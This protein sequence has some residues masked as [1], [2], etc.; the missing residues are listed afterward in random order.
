MMI[1]SMKNELAWWFNFD[2]AIAWL[3]VQVLENSH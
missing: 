1:V 2:L 3:W